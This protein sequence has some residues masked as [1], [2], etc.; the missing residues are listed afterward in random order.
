MQGDSVRQTAV[1]EIASS[2]WFVE[3]STGATQSNYNMKV[4]L[5]DP[6]RPEMERELMALVD[7]LVGAN[8]V[9]SGA[10]VVPPQFGPG[11]YYFR[12]F[13]PPS[14]DGGWRIVVRENQ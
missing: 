10:V 11:K 7:E 5:G 9:H 4:L 1:F 13:G 6:A 2:S 8:G 14:W 12:I 3:W